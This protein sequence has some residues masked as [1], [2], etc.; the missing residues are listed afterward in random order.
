MKTEIG[1]IDKM[2][3]KTQV[4]TLALDANNLVWE[5]AHLALYI[6]D[7]MERKDDEWLDMLNNA[8]NALRKGHPDKFY[9][10]L[11]RMKEAVKWDKKD[12]MYVSRNI[13]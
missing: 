8:N 12:D 5:K 4:R 1:L 6:M 7:A 9:F 3:K 10:I 13:R 11:D 2:D